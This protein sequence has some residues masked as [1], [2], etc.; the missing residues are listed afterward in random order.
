MAIIIEQGEVNKGGIVLSKP[1]MLPE[2]IKVRI[3]IEP[4]YTDDDSQTTIPDEHE[5][6]AKLPFFGMWADRE[7]MCD[8]DIS[9]S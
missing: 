6:L 1:L 4:I 5:N 7:D 2:E 8:N 3:Q 9:H